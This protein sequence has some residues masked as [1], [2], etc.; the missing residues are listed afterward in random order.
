[1]QHTPRLIA[2][3]I[4]LGLLLAGLFGLRYMQLQEQQAAMAQQPPPA[5]I[6]AVRAQSSR[7]PGAVTAIGDLRAVNGVRVANE[8]AGVVDRIEFESG[9]R[10]QTGDLLIHLDDQTDVAALATAQAEARRA[11]QQFERFSDLIGQSA[12]SQSQFDEAR[13][14]YEAAQARVSEQQAL[15]AKKSVRAPF[16]G[17]L[18]LRQVDQGEFLAVGTPIVEINTLDPIQVD[19]TIG[20][21]ELPRIQTGDS[22]EVRVAAYPDEIFSGEIL[23][24]ESSVRPATRTIEVR[25]RLGNPDRLLRPGMFAEVTVFEGIDRPVITVPRTAISYNTYGDFVY[26]VTEGEDQQVVER[27]QVRTGESRDGQIEVI[28]GLEAGALIVSSGLQRL[29]NGQAVRVSPDGDGGESS[30][31]ETR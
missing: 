28:E 16:S 2:G 27:V 20:E 25:A 18:G 30:N 26:R 14:T 1:M 12:V 11:R 9:Q 24:L 5:L 7:W 21:A 22:V 13:A 3:L 10:V 29:R 6:E 23:A 4:V 31:A 8:I 15:L 17:T 19:F